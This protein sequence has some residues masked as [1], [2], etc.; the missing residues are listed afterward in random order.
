MRIVVCGDS[1]MTQDRRLQAKGKHFSELLLP[2]EVINLARGGISNIGICFQIDQ[3]IK[4]NPNVVIVGTTD[5][6]RIEIPSGNGKFEERNGLKNIIYTQ[7]ASASIDSKYVGDATAPIISDTIPTVIGEETDLIDS[8]TLSTDVRQAVKQYFSY[9]YHPEVKLLADMWA[10][11]YW[12]G[13]LEKAGIKVIRAKEILSHLYQA[14]YTSPTDWVFHT[15][16]SEQE[17]AANIIKKLLGNN[18]T[19][20]S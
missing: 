17:K 1:F 6:G 8:Y 13:L 9:M 11:G 3:A 5:S 18:S 19:C 10:I 7:F 20:I 2:H 16:F 4:L 14:A 12:V 15:E